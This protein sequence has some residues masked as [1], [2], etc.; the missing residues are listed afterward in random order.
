MHDHEG[1]F[2]GLNEIEIFGNI[3]GFYQDCGRVTGIHYGI[4]YDY[5]IPEFT[6]NTTLARA[7][8]DSSHT[9]KLTAFEDDSQ[10][11]VLTSSDDYLGSWP[12][13]LHLSQYNYRYFTE[14]PS[15]LYLSV[16]AVAPFE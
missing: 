2:G 14:M 11:C 9:F 4:D 13:G 1:L 6:P 7:V 12:T 5:Y 8:P 3:N 15:E 16:R 10:G